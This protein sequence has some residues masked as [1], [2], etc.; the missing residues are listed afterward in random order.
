MIEERLFA[1][2]EEAALALGRD[3]ARC[4]GDALAARGRATVA[5]SGG[6]TPELI[7]PALAGAGLDWERISVTL[8]DERWVGADDDD[9]N[10]GLTRR[11]L[12]TGGAAAARLVGLKTPARSPQE[13][14]A[15][16][17]AR[18][19]AL[20]WPLDVV[21]LG[22]GEDGHVAS[23][24]PGDDGWGGAMGR[25]VAVAGDDRRSPRMSLTPA[26][27]LDA[28]RVLLILGGAAKGR[29][30]DAAKRPGSVADLPARLV[31]R[32]AR[33]PM[34]IYRAP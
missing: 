15:A 14:L 29:A 8:T 5:V 32:Q 4:L 34:T 10:E 18:L 30:L 7:F 9:S 23:L 16:T 17:A 20:N 27:L 26:A 3:L 21:F 13:G 12:L 25:C 28:R 1:T 6:R 11:L 24:F 33:V 19:D 31:V 2:L 22:M